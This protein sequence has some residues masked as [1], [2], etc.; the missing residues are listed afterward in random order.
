MEVSTERRRSL[1]MAATLIVGSLAA[2]HARAQTWGA[3][4]T[5]DCKGLGVRQ[6]SARLWD[7]TGDWAAACAATPATV[8]GQ[9]F[10]SP[11]RCVN[12]GSFGMWGEFDVSD[13]SCLPHWGTPF[14]ADACRGLKV[15]QYSARLW[16]IP[17][18]VSWE[19]ACAATPTTILGQS[20]SSP[21][22]CVNKGLFGM[23]GEFDVS[24]TF[25]LPRW[26]TPFQR[27]ECRSLEI[28]QYSAR[29]WDIPGDV[30]WE[31]ACAVTSAT[32]GAQSFPSPTRCV[33]KGL[34]GMWG[35]FDV[36]DSSCPDNVRQLQVTRFNTSALTDADADTIV[37]GATR[38]LSTSDGTGDVACNIRLVRNGPVTAFQAGT[39]TINSR[40]DFDDVVALPGFV[41]VVNLIQW[42]SVFAANFIGCSPTPGSSIVVMRHRANQ[43]GILWAHE[44]GHTR[45]L[46]HR[47]DGDA[48][49]H[50]T[51]A[52]THLQ[53][54]ASECDAFRR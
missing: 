20:F 2:Q 48:I 9:S 19:D 15:R 45:G 38:I 53:V 37:R 30:S 26:G 28:R 49:M 41:K 18:G 27:D 52:T 43:E 39:G 8:M 1:L 17:A 24:D 36:S 29:L 44:Y 3:F 50:E 10:S 35:E 31:D 21:T 32:V 54:N 11:T 13:T 14:Q 5:D 16:D 22:R 12:K 23:W 25:C 4:Q 7:I 46:D 6:Y 40:Q 33:N 34:F 42:C 47:N 51:I